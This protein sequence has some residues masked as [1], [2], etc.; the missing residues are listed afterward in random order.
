MDC[1]EFNDRIRY[2]DVAGDIGFMAMDLDFRGRR[3]LSDELIGA[4]AGAVRDESLPLVLPF[5][6]CYRAF[7]RGKVESLLLDETEVPEEQREGAAERARRYF[8][9]A[10]G[11]AGQRRPKTAV[12]MV[13]LT[14]SGK[15]HLANALGN[16]VEASII[17]SDAIRDEL[18]SR[19]AS[20][21]AYGAGRYGEDE[22]AAI[23]TAMRER[24]DTYLRAGDSVILDATHV[25]RRDRDAVYE[26]A[27][28]SG[29]RPVV[30]HVR[31]DDATTRKHMESRAAQPD[32]ASEGR[33][34]IYHAQRAVFEPVDEAT[35][36]VAVVEV[37]GGDTLAI[38]VERVVAALD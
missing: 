18:T 17:S 12:V 6:K 33:W 20:A 29:A 3:D 2:G 16:R 35:E 32:A 28:S 1:I 21:D 14:G 13:G 30:V 19:T 27:R 31:A 36:D 10:S 8:A 7:V 4:Y 37:D 5:Y 22:R 15:S 38:N 26:L 9:L 34:E 24:A 11:Y 25:A 23:Y